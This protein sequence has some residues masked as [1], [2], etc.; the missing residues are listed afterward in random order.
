M[1]KGLPENNRKMEHGDLTIDGLIHEGRSLQTRIGIFA[2]NLENMEAGRNTSS[3][4][5]HSRESYAIKES[6]KHIRFITSVTG[7][8]EETIKD[9]FSLLCKFRGVDYGGIYLFNSQEEQLDLVC[10]YN[11]PGELLIRAISFP[12]NVRNLK[13][14]L[15]RSIVSS[16]LQD[17]PLQARLILEKHGMEAFAV[18]PLNCQSKVVGC[19]IMS[20]KQETFLSRFELLLVEEL[21]LRIS[22]AIVLHDAHV[23]LKVAKEDL[24]NISMNLKSGSLPLTGNCVSSSLN[25]SFLGMMAEIERLCQTI[26]HAADR[27]TQKLSDRQNYISL[28]F[29]ENRFNEIFVEIDFIIGVIK[30]LSNCAEMQVLSAG[31]GKHGYNETNHVVSLRSLVAFYQAINI[32]VHNDNRPSAACAQFYAGNYRPLQWPVTLSCIDMQINRLVNN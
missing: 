6:A 21:S 18:I 32:L 5:H 12:T 14:L 9:V 27:I 3:A 26:S 17:I 23:R 2:R 15:K 1:M 7:T 22:R 20:S 30:K 10:H 19:L 16:N 13:S 31:I 4:T 25:L 8:L 29:H 28:A 24:K 11:L